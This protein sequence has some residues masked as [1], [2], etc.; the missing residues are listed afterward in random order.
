MMEKARKHSSI[1]V[2]ELNPT[3]VQEMNRIDFV[4]MSEDEIE[5][6]EK[7]YVHLAA[8][9]ICDLGVTDMISAANGVTQL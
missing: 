9:V 6:E 2:D 7:E 1:V 5:E 8:Y 3:V 4:G